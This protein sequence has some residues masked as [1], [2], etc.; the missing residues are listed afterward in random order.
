MNFSL[1]LTAS[2]TGS[3]ARPKIQPGSDIYLTQSD[4]KPDELRHMYKDFAQMVFPRLDM[5]DHI[6]DAEHWEQTIV[7]RSIGASYSKGAT[8]ENPLVGLTAERFTTSASYG[9]DT[10]VTHKGIQSNT[11]L[12]DHVEITARRSYRGKLGYDLSPRKPPAWT[13]W[14]PFRQMKS[15]N[16]PKQM[17][18][19]EITYLP[20]TL[21]FTLADGEYSRDYRSDTR[22]LKT[23]IDKRLGIDQGF[24]LKMRPVKP[25]LDMD[26][27]F[28]VVRKFDEDIQTWQRSWR[29]FIGEKVLERDPS[30]REY[31]VTYGEMRRTQHAGLRLSPQFADWLTHSA[32]Y[33]A[34]YSHF[35]QN[36]PGDSTDFLSTGVGTSFN[37]RSGLRIRTLLNDLADATEKAKGLSGTFDVMEKGLSKINLNDFNFTYTASL[38]LKNEYLDTAFLGNEDI[39]AWDFFLYQIGA[40]NRGFGDVVTG[41]ID[42]YDAFGG[43]WYRYG[44]YGQDSPQKLYQN[45]LRSTSQNW[46]LSTSMRLPQPLDLSFSGVSLGWKRK[47]SHKPDTLFIDTVITWP[48]IHAGANTRILDRITFLKQIMQSMDLSSGY[49]FQKDSALTYD[50]I[51]ITRTYGW[52]PLIS[53]KGTLKKWPISMVYSHNFSISNSESRSRRESIQDT[54]ALNKRGT[55]KKNH[56]NTATVS[57]KLRPHKKS[58]IQV[59]RW[60][61]PIKGELDMG[62]D[63]KHSHATEKPT[64]NGKPTQDRPSE[65]RTDMSVEPHISYYF[66]ENV[67]GELRYL[68]SKLTDDK[69][70]EE[71]ITQSFTMLIR[72]NF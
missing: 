56:G 42:D 67:K 66:T 9:R 69:L 10:T 36:R 19:Y 41:D 12:G 62:V 61:I 47:Y 28:A 59:L 26:F 15:K 20:T 24:Q 68:A 64:V 51:D 37:F 43:A 60:T 16:F 7:N 21:N 40:K 57:Y 27:D 8:S 45:D 38:D 32:D 18:Q 44:K 39:S 55:E 17:K 25:V 63:G 46:S 29:N 3:L 58:E 72:I 13:K 4:G 54:S 65:D 50:R 71:T 35:P 6:T 48:E 11:L 2:L 70:K 53:F 49:S 33:S 5:A 22:T 34:N 23:Q 52:E 31:F 14:E 30:W 1:P